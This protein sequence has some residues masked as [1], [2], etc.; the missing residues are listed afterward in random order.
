MFTLSCINKSTNPSFE[1]KK[2]SETELTTKKDDEQ[3]V[4]AGILSKAEVTSYQY[5]THQLNGYV[6]DG[7]PENVGKEILFALKTDKV[8]LD[9]W[10]GKRLIITGEE[11]EGYPIENGP[12]LIDVKEIEE[13]QEF[14][15][16]SKAIKLFLKIEAI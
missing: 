9:K 7:N 1:D 5:G 14:K 13:D 4:W 11:V 3:K 12:L 10:I 2:S 6:L 16:L 15:D 8:N